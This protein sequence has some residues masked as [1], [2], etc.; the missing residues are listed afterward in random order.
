MWALRTGAK[1]MWE[2]NET[3][4]KIVDL[5]GQSPKNC[6]AERSRIR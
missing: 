3:Y 1:G 4:L 6:N 2:T 5:Q